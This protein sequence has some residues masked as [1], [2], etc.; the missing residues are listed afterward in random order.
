MDKLI[1]ETFSIEAYEDALNTGIKFPIL[2]I[3]K[4]KNTEMINFIISKKIPRMAI[5]SSKID[6]ILKEEKRINKDACIFVY[7]SNEDEFIKKYL[8]TKLNI[9]FYTDKWNLKKGLCEGENCNTY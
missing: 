2:S 6:Y 7:T 1:V 3:P 4:T 9:I 5:H 8:S